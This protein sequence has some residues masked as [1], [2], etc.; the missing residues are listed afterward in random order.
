[1]KVY[2]KWQEIRI[3][4][5]KSSKLPF[6]FSY[7]IKIAFMHKECPVCGCKM[8]NYEF[9]VNRLPTIQHCVPI[10]KGGKHKLG[11]IAVVCR[12]CNEIIKNK[13]TGK[14]NSDEVSRVWNAI[15]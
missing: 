3:K 6:S 14:L 2:P 7:K 11:N 9:S 1:M 12:S 15:K 5:L 8:Q 10:S 4:E 13:I